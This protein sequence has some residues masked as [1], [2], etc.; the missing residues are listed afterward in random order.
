MKMRR[1]AVVLSLAATSPLLGSAVAPNVANA[2]TA[3]ADAW[4]VKDDGSKWYPAGPDTCVETGFSRL[5]NVG[6]EP[7]N[8]NIPGCLQGVGFNIWITAPV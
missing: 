2:D 7:T 4:L 6:T 1:L 5:T 3:C 8:D